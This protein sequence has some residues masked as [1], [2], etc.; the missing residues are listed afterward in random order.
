MSKKLCADA[1]KENTTHL[2]V[3][4]KYISENHR[5][6]IFLCWL[7]LVWG[8]REA[9]ASQ[10][11]AEILH[12]TFGLWQE[13]TRRKLV[14]T[15][16]EHADFLQKSHS[17]LGFKPT[18]VLL[19][20]NSANHLSY[21]I[22]PVYGAFP[23]S[24]TIFFLYFMF[25]IF[26][27]ISSTEIPPIFEELLCDRWMLVWEAECWLTLSPTGPWG[28]TEPGSPRCPRFPSSPWG[29]STPWEPGGPCGVKNT[30]QEISGS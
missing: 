21:C 1:P 3:S 29:P 24:S 30:S 11:P 10:R 26:Y 6:F 18:T 19:W 9:A 2:D 15:W 23:M 22:S 13:T 25:L 8:H 17:C 28:P 27:L 14:Q 7:E 5:S 16:E 4:T 20:G 12:L